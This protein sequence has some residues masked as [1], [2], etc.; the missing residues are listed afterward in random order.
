MTLSSDC[1]SITLSQED[2]ATLIGLTDLLWSILRHDP[3]QAA[4]TLSGVLLSLSALGVTRD[5]ATVEEA[6]DVLRELSLRLRRANGETE[7][8]KVAIG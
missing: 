3:S 5:T 6:V 8:E 4:G 1:N 7:P 2:A